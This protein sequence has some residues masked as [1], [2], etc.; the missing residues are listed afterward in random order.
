MTENIIHNLIIKNLGLVEYQP[1]WASMQ[2]FTQNRSDETPD[3]IWVLEHPSVFT[4]GQAGKKEH[5]LFNSNIP[6]IQCDRGGQITY[7]GPGQIVV[8]ILVNLR[9]SKFTIRELVCAIEKAVIACL[10]ELNIDCYADRNAPGVYLDI[11]GEKH[12]ICSLGL[13][14]KRGCT[15]HGLA[16]NYNMD[17]KP[18]SYINPCGFENL[19]VTQVHEHNPQIQKQELIKIL[20]KQLELHLLK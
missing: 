5:L 11:N 10:K 3:E 17:L 14:V 4:L 1:T 9:R 19:K 2:E 12:K 13:R 20:C 6:V 16:L 18:F 7:H 15:Y 8:Y